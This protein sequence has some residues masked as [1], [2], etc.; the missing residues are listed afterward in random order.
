MDSSSPYS[1]PPVT[2][3]IGTED[4]S[5]YVPEVLLQTLRNCSSY[6]PFG[7][8]VD[9]PDLDADS[10]HVIVHFLHTGTYQ[11]LADDEDLTSFIASK[12]FRKAI[13]ILS[14][15][16]KYGLP[17]LQQLAKVEVE[18]RCAHMDI[19]EIV[20]AVNEEFFTLPQ[21]DTSWMKELVSQKAEKAFKYDDTVFS[22]DFFSTIGSHTLSGFL[23][24]SLVRLYQ[25]QVAE[26]RESQAVRDGCS[27]KVDGTIVAGETLRETPP[28]SSGSAVG[29]EIG[30]GPL[31]EEDSCRWLPDLPRPKEKMTTI[32]EVSLPLEPSSDLQP[33]PDENPA[34]GETPPAN[35]DD[36]WGFNWSAGVAPS[37]KKKKKHS[38]DKKVRLTVSQESSLE[39]S[40]IIESDLIEPERVV[41]HEVD[42]KPVSDTTEIP[43]SDSCA[44]RLEHLSEVNGWKTCRPCE[45][46]VREIASRIHSTG[47]PEINCVGAAE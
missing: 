39:P 6:D 21:D 34:V 45:V 23:A 7:R 12:E 13:L 33:V 28:A 46:Y 44:L 10:A 47:I 27:Q 1:S 22:A 25:K 32:T 3:R 26:L 42:V 4:Q 37:K 24:Q 5:Y 16:K 31:V 43:H 18:Q 36:L 29:L 9:L 20:Q 38:K 15:A 17:E 2:L 30:T 40:M 14:A 8:T 35:L 41:N 11:T 19:A